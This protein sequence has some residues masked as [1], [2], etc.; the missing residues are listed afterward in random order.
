EVLDP[1]E[2]L[3]DREAGVGES[4]ELLFRDRHFEGHS[5]PARHLLVERQEGPLATFGLFR[6]GP[7]LRDAAAGCKSE[8]I[9]NALELRAAIR[10]ALRCFFDARGYLEVDTPV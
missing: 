1:A 3:F 8:R 2:E 4:L 10:S 7:T 5:L 6:H 9:M